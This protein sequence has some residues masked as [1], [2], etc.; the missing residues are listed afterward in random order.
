MPISDHNYSY[1]IVHCLID[2]SFVI[3]NS[4]QNN[5]KDSRLKRQAILHWPEELGF[6]RLAIFNYSSSKLL[7]TH[8]IVSPSSAFLWHSGKTWLYPSLQIM[9]S[10]KIKHILYDGAT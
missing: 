6:I 8:I 1:I 4:F 10:F 2:L 9:G 3:L 5:L 7:E